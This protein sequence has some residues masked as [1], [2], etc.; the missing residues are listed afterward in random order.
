MS[1]SPQPPRGDRIIVDDPYSVGDVSEE[2]REAA[3]QAFVSPVHGGAIMATLAALAGGLG[4]SIPLAR[5]SVSIG[6]RS[7][8][9]MFDF[10][11]PAATVEPGPVPIR[12]TVRSVVLV[13]REDTAGTWTPPVERVSKRRRRRLRGKGLR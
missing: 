5:M 12:Q 10:Y 2:A 1:P 7:P 4:A 11:D 3:R 9:A 6:P 13:K 8:E